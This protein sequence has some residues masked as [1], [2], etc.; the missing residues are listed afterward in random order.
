LSSKCK[1]ISGLKKC[2]QESPVA[3]RCNTIEWRGGLSLLD[4]TEWNQ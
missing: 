1:L 3:L 4:V 2:P